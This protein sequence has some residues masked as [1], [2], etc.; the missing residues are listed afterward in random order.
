M[1]A[2]DFSYLARL[3]RRRAGLILTQEKATLAMRRLEPVMRRFGFRSLEP[4]F[5]ELRLDCEGLADAVI[6]A[7][8]VNETC[9]FR[10]SHQ[11]VRLQ[12]HVIPKLMQARAHDKRL[13]IWSAAA[14]SGQEVY[15]LAMM[16]DGLD[17]AARGWQ[18][19]LIATDLS[20]EA[21]ARAQAGHYTQFEL[22]RGLSFEDIARHFR[23][24]ES[25][26]TI[27]PRLKA[28]V[29]FRRFNLLDSYGWLGDLD[30][31]LCRNVLFYFDPATRAS[32]LDRMAE[33]LSPDGVLL[34]GAAERV[35][36]CSD[37]LRE[38]EAGFCALAQPPS[39]RAVG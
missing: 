24:Q 23:A 20:G 15:S 21:L 39:L 26:F 22:Q 35:D 33:T 28:M 3:L 10:D 16:L 1:R 37:A 30:L 19:D 14:S 29:K 13:R 18:V 12:T 11:F 25:G 27:S 17:L 6:E 7:M 31:I 4:L 8:M 36:G 34:L 32:V 9:F 2:D 5:K 38:S